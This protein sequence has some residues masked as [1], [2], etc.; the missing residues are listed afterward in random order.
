MFLL[1]RSYFFT[2]G[3]NRRNFFKVVTS[4]LNGAILIY[5]KDLEKNK[6]RD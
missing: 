3:D 2:F 6:V 4:S 5:I 1:K